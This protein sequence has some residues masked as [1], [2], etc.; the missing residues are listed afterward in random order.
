MADTDP[1]AAEMAAAQRTMNASPS[2][3]ELAANERAGVVLLLDGMVPLAV[4]EVSRWSSVR[5]EAEM[6]RS[7]ELIA[8][9]ADDLGVVGDHLGRRNSPQGAVLTALAR[10][11]AVGSLRPGGVTFAGRHWCSAAHEDCPN[12][13]GPDS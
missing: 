2:A 7:G 9:S 1:V 11:I 13:H 12:A 5:Q 4:F 6:A 8:S 3:Y 10:G